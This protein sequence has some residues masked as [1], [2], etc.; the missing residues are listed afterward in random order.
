[1]T[2]ALLQEGHRLNKKPEIVA[3]AS[4]HGGHRGRIV[5]EADID[6]SIVVR[7]RV[8]TQREIDR[9][10]RAG[11]VNGDQHLAGTT[12]RDQWESAGVAV[13]KLSAVNPEI[14]SQGRSVIGDYV[15]WEA[16]NN[17][18]KQLGRD[19]RRCVSDVVLHDM[20]L[21][22]WG[23]KWR[24]FPDSFLT[25]ALDRLGRHYGTVFR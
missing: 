9:L 11:R 13:G 5:R 10:F 19:Q 8:D 2:A 7:I 20:N 17:A 22:E 15:A 25:A 6:G 23:R 4:L 16:Y 1:M 24:C 18:I 12:L 14:Y 3:E 21:N